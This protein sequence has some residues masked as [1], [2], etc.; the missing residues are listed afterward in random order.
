M[1]L[2]C[3][4][5]SFLNTDHKVLAEF[6]ANALARQ[7]VSERGELSKQS[8]LELGGIPILLKWCAPEEPEPL[9]EAVTMALC[10][11]STLP[12]AQIKLSKDGLYTLINLARSV[13]GT[14]PLVWRYIRYGNYHI[15]NLLL[16]L[17]FCEFR[18]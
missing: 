8:C 5:I 3:I 4:F 6:A 14:M 1:P 18:Y 15:S 2:E 9:L 10:N 16:L 13:M 7:I 11:L 17:Y 12:A